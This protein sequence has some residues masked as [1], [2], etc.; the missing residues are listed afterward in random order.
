MRTS[1]GDIPLTGFFFYK[2]RTKTFKSFFLSHDPYAQTNDAG[3]DK[4]KRDVRRVFKDTRATQ[5]K[6]SLGNCP[7]AVQLRL[8]MT[9]NG[10]AYQFL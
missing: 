2:D 9:C 5:A 1:L 10:R 7:V 8:L 3:P 6:A 4:D